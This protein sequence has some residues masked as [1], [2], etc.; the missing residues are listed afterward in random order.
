MEEGEHNTLPVPISL[1]PGTRSSSW[2]QVP[3]KPTTLVEGGVVLITNVDGS[4]AWTTA[5]TGSI[6]E[7][8][9]TIRSAEQKKKDIEDKE[10]L[11]R[12]KKDTNEKLTSGAK[13]NGN[14]RRNASDRRKRMSRRVNNKV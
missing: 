2:G 4:V 1:A 6:G 7:P 9:R 11:E 5:G 12:W 14:L 13:P 3:A 10:K 8:K